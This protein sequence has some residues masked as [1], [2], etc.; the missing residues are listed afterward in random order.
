MPSRVID[1]VRLIAQDHVEVDVEG[2][3]RV[4]ADDRREPL[5]GV[6]AVQL[7]QRGQIEGDAGGAVNA[8]AGGVNLPVDEDRRRI[9]GVVLADQAPTGAHGIAGGEVEN[10]ARRRD[11]GRRRGHDE[12]AVDVGRRGHF[13]QRVT[14]VAVSLKLRQ[15]EGPRIG[16]E[17]EVRRRRIAG[18]VSSAHQVAEND[19]G[20]ADCCDQQDAHTEAQREGFHG[21]TS[22]QI[23]LLVKSAANRLTSIVQPD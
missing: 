11:G 16:V 22:L 12:N 8:D 20:G 21:S 7:A 23:Q 14:R 5:D 19:V 9:G 10:N 6:V 2:Y 1:H 15:A 17:A 13:H 4:A 18:A 3:A